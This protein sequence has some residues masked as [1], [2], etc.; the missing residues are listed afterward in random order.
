MSAISLPAAPWHR[1]ATA[2]RVPREQAEARED[3]PA[4]ACGERILVRTRSA[5]GCALVGTDRAAHVAAADGWRTIPWLDV[6][7]AG[8]DPTE[9]Q[10]VVRLWPDRGRPAIVRIPSDH[11]FA[12]FVAERVAAAQVLR[13][14]V[15]LSQHAVALVVALRQPG[16]VS[17][18][19]RVLVD[20]ADADT[21]GVQEAADRV[22][23]QLR[24]LVGC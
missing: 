12:V 20:G 3:F 14:R 21:Q 24:E 10:T 1:A 15:P 11:R 13:R 16:D 4:L 8:W 2:R 6:D 19:W 9:G 18:Q 22:L 23:A 7:S 5:P 17:L